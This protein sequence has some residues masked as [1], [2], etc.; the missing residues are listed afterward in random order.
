MRRSRRSVASA[1]VILM[2]AC[3]IAAGCGG[4][5]ATTSPSDAV[6]V[7]RAERAFVKAWGEATSK[8]KNRCEAKN[9]RDPERCFS[10]AFRPESRSAVAHF[11][12]AIEEVMANGVGGECAA[13]LEEALV[14][15]SQIPSFPGDA[16]VACRAESR[17]Q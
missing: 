11:T 12:N 8:S 6:A 15:P 14:E 17:G 16:T 4:S 2:V 13:A 7:A 9:V 5:S 3:S 1:T 10:L